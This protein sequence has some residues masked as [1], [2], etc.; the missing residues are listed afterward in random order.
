VIKGIVIIAAVAL[1]R[2][3]TRGGRTS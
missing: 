3:N 1:D 2:Q